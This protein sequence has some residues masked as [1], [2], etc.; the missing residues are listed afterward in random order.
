SAQNVLTLERDTFFRVLTVETT[1]ARFKML[2]VALP[3]INERAAIYGVHVTLKFDRSGKTVNPQDSTC[4]IPYDQYALRLYLRK[5]GPKYPKQAPQI[6][7]LPGEDCI[8]S[9]EV[10]CEVV[11]DIIKRD[12]LDRTP[13]NPDSAYVVPKLYL[14][15]QFNVPHHSPK[16]E[17][18]IGGCLTQFYLNKSSDSLAPWMQHF[19][20][21]NIRAES[22]LAFDEVVQPY[23]VTCD[24]CEGIKKK[25][26]QKVKIGSVNTISVMF[27]FRGNHE[28]RPVAGIECRG[29]LGMKYFIT[30]VH[31]GRTMNR[32][33][34]GFV[35]VLGFGAF[36]P[37]SLWILKGAE[38][39]IQLATRPFLNWQTQAN[40]RM[41]V[42]LTR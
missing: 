22:F 32:A 26:P 12:T 38:F 15:G 18:G 41:L 30:E 35:L 31:E 21:V 23:V 40:L 34:D 42:H 3:S 11:K 20:Q 28:L 1:A 13:K 24:S 10:E 8:D 9:I 16:F 14:T 25:E 7:Y 33:E 36:S 39:N 19:L 4:E 6:V 29:Y 27:E 5:G 37:K 2:K 17:F